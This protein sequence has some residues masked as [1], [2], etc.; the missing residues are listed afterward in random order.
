[1]NYW[2]YTLWEKITSIIT[3]GKIKFAN[4][5]NKSELPA[6][7]FSSNSDW[8]QTVR[9]SLLTKKGISELFSRDSLY[10][11]SKSYHQILPVRIELDTQKVSLVSWDDHKKHSGITKKLAFELERYAEKWGANTDEWGICYTEVSIKFCHLPFEI[12][13]GRQWL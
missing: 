12:W 2:H 11:H 13:N 8:E 4:P 6:V 3:D 9:K 7:W 1:M 10:K 5:Y